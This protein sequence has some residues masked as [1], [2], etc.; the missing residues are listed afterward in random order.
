M[1]DVLKDIWEVLPK[2]TGKDMPP[3]DEDLVERFS[4]VP[5]IME[6]DDFL[7]GQKDKLWKSEALDAFG[8]KYLLGVFATREE[9]RKAF[10]DWNKEYEA[11]Q[12]AMKVDLEQ[13]GKQEQARLEAD[14]SGRDRIK[15][16]LEAARR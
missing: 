12:A 4:K 3:L 15:A 9:A 5:A 13:L 10:D 6:G 11:A 2:L 8:M 14:T 7:W 1:G 16:V